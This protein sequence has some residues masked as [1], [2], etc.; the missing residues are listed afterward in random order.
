MFICYICHTNKYRNWQYDG[1]SFVYILYFTFLYIKLFLL[2]HGI[3]CRILETF[4]INSCI[5]NIGVI[6]I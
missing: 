1:L 4:V 5:G 6:V 3:V 2:V